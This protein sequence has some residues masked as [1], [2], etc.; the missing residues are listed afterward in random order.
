MF[1]FTKS[2]PHLII[3]TQTFLFHKI[4]Q[5]AGIQPVT[6]DLIHLVP[7][8]LCLLQSS[9]VLPPVESGYGA[10]VRAAARA[11]ERAKAQA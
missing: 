11:S 4:V 3:K 9:A 10:I 5:K 6:V 8:C 7:S 1:D 2:Y